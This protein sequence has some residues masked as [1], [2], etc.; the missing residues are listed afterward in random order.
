MVVACVALVFSLAGNA[1]AARVLITSSSQI[2][3]GAV[4]GADVKN[5]SLGV[6]DL[7]VKARA[8]LKGAAGPAGSAGAPGAT[9]AVGPA[10]P[11]G[12][13]GEKGADGAAGSIQG[14]AA[15]GDL[16]G[17]YPNPTIAAGKVG[18]TALATNAVSAT[19]IL[20]GA[21]TNAKLADDAVSRAEVAPGAIGL[22]EL[23]VQV[24]QQQLVITTGSNIANGSCTGYAQT[25]VVDVPV[26]STTLVLQTYRGDG[27]I[28]EGTTSS[29][30]NAI[31]VR[32]CNRTGA[33]ADPPAIGEI[34]AMVFL[35]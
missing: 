34:S 9:G 2:K 13:Q 29:V 11:A 27:W 5:R 20:S 21:V 7:S 35:P 19:K 16:A 22:P 26:G 33:T 8:A 23:D 15:G 25:A 18:A 31:R 1:V 32:M 14:A 12:P 6:T 3:N 28:A 30:G 17:S 24:L 4:T 10:G